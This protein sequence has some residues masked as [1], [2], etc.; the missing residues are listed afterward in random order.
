MRFRVRRH[1]GTPP[2]E[3]EPAPEAERDEDSADR[4]APSPPEVSLTPVATPVAPVVVPR[5]VQLVLLPIGLL[6]LWA[7]A[8]A[9]GS[10][11]LILIVAG[12]IALI[13][14]PVVR[15][16]S[17]RLP[18][19]LAIL[20]VYLGGFAILAGIVLERHWRPTPTPVPAE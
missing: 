2:A 11:L 14:A 1:D 9:A 18:R 7:L 16:L 5:W 3:G 6:G 10:V 20:I 8:R 19:G 17:R 13:L 15:L 4:A 12:M